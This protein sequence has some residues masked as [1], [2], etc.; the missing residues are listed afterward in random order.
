MVYRKKMNTQNKVLFVIPKY[1]NEYYSLP[2]MPLVGIGYL[3]EVLNK[4]NINNKVI[5]MRFNYKYIYLKNYIL[6]YKPKYIC[7]T[8]MTFNY[9]ESYKLIKIIK[10]DF[11]NIKII[12]GGSHIST[13]KIDVINEC[14]YIDCI[15]INEG[16]YILLDIVKKASFKNVNGIMYRENGHI[17]SNYKNNNY[18]DL[19]SVDFP[20][21]K[22][23]EL[24]KYYTKAIPISTTRG[25][26]YSCGFCPVSRSV[27]N[28]FRK[29]LTNSI[30]TEFKYWYNKGRKRFVIVDDNFTLDR[31]RVINICNQLIK[32]K[33]KDLYIILGEGVRCDKVDYDLLKKMYIS[34]FKHICFGVESVNNKVLKIMNKR[35]TIEQIE[36]SIKDSINI[37]YNVELFFLIGYIGE[38]IKD[39]KSIIKFAKKYPIVKAHFYNIIPF[40][41]TK[42]YYYVI[43]N[44]LLLYKPEHYLNNISQN[45][46]KPLFYT[47]ELNI[48]QR[49]KYLK[50]FKKL[51][52]K[53]MFKYYKN[54][55]AP[56]L[57]YIIRI[58][59]F[60]FFNNIFNMINRNN[61]LRLIKNKLV[62][63]IS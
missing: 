56:L 39:L 58:S 55:T 48:N 45:D 2:T 61:T 10:L 57:Y 33:F 53:I 5:D 13:F 6:K 63:P 16:E 41:Y 59:K 36:E 34:G 46:N 44:N 26:P 43:K 28:R 40:P 12:C 42:L 17:I 49:K 60:S 50:I 52:N 31:N 62:K 35:E 38:T 3:S 37:G 8:L 20:K 47:K 29:R 18:I 51:S 30:I 1:G 54:N 4:N 11:P 14:K 19:N 15:V 21:Y 24:N 23:F 27:G 22:S 25:C 7:L 32:L 9:K